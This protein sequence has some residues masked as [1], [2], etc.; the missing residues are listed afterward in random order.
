MKRRSVR[1]IGALLLIAALAGAVLANSDSAR[2]RVDTALFYISN[3]WVSEALEHLEQA[4][5]VA[6]E[7]TEAQLL[8]AMLL[9]SLDQPDLAM[10]SY[11]RAMDSQPDALPYGVFIG[12]LYFAAGRLDEAQAAY[13]EALQA[14]PDTGLAYYGL[15]RIMEL[16]GAEA[17]IDMYRAVAEHAPD[18]IDG[19]FRLGRLLR[20][21]GQLEQ[22]LEHLLHANR[23]NG[24]LPLVRLE[25][26]Y[27]YESLDRTSEAEH[28]YRMVLRLDPDNVEANTRLERLLQAADANT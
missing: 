21:S 17:A 28:E 26:A 14:F 25:L 6:P 27:T 13:E 23:L 20:R 1:V 8:L 3:G 22:A 24:R 12:D 16:R 10:A 11:R 15:G 19:R 2:L 18:F 7:Y 4:V 9:D 5:R